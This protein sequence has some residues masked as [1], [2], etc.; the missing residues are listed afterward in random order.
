[1]CRE[2]FVKKKERILNFIRRAKNSD[3]RDA[4]PVRIYARNVDSANQKYHVNNDRLKIP[5]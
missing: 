1:M 5:S 4:M 2:Q 3:T